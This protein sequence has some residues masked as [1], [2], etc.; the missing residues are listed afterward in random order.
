[1]YPRLTVD[2]AKLQHNMASIVEM[3][4]P[5]GTAVI[6]VTKVCGGRPDVARAFLAAGAVGLADAR[7]ANLKRLRQEGLEAPLILLRS[8]ALSVV[9]EVVETVQISANSEPVVLKALSEAAGAR[10]LEHQ[11]LLMV[12]LGELR[13]GVWED[14]LLNLYTYAR[15]LPN[16]TVW[17]IGANFACLNGDAPTPEYFQRLVDLTKACGDP[18]LRISGGNS[19]ALH[20]MRCGQWSGT[21][22]SLINNLRIGESAFLGWDIV[23]KTPLPGCCQD[24]CR[25][26]AEVIE[27]Q[28]KPTP[29]SRRQRAVVALGRQDIGAGRV[30]PISAG[31]EV[32]GVTSDHLVLEV[33]SAAQLKVGSVVTFAVDYGALLGL[34]TSPYVTK[35]A[36]R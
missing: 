12:D 27:V 9:S 24:V 28:V 20:V 22:T 29:Q 4:R 16:L 8:P 32:V 26:L 18:N 2:L 6:G 23:D 21:W 25:L 17:G 15:S 3:C 11:V 5:F 7:L 36:H 34:F 30:W 33:G 10:G 1:M 14:E 19:S 13:E 31:M 35:D